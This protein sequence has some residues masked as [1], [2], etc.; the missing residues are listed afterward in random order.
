MNNGYLNTETAQI[1]NQKLL[2]NPI[3]LNFAMKSI[4]M[5]SV[6]FVCKQRNVKCKFCIICDEDCYLI[7]LFFS[8][9]NFIISLCKISAKV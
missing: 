8:G 1:K 5:F 6:V 4:S 9:S 2:F 3:F 7:D